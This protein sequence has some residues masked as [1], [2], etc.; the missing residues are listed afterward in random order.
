MRL[1]LTAILTLLCLPEFLVAADTRAQSWKPI[2]RA[3]SSK[4]SLLGIDYVIV[5]QSASQRLAAAVDDLQRL[6]AERYDKNLQRLD[7]GKTKQAIHFEIADI[8]EGGAFSIRRER[9]RVII[10][11]DDHEAW[12]NAI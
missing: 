5:P 8:G 7:S 2:Y 10:R 6:F 3:G 12:A 4:L 9:T 11:G 1:Y